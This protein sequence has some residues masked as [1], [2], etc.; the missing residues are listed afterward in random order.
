MDTNSL[1]RVAL[2]EAGHAVCAEALGAK[3][4]D[5]V[6]LLSGDHMRN[7]HDGCNL[8]SAHGR[9][10]YGQAVGEFPT[11]IIAAAGQAA[12]SLADAYPPPPMPKPTQ[13]AAKVEAPRTTEHIEAVEGMRPGQL[14]ILHDDHVIALYAINRDLKNPETWAPAVARVRGE[15]LLIVKQHAVDVVRV[16]TALLQQGYIMPEEMRLL[17]DGIAPQPTMENCA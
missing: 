4:Q 9:A 6:M 12:E 14:R 15:A 7:F 17:L 16:A 11:A 13:E 5:A 2:H 10:S 3:A 1:W 8:W